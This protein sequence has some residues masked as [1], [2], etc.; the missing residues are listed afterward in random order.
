[1]EKGLGCDDQGFK[2]QNQVPY[3]CPRMV[4]HQ[5][6]QDGRDTQCPQYDTLLLTVSRELMPHI[7][8][9]IIFRSH[10]THGTIPNL[11]IFKSLVA[12]S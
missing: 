12:V 9:S 8:T 7:H 3:S 6:D 10:I 11:A 2:H 4:Q 5:Y 1:M